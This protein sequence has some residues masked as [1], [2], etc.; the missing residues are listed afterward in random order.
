MSL[1]GKWYPLT[2]KLYFD[3]TNNMTEYEAC[4]MRVRM[5]YEMKIKRLRVL[6]DSLSIVHQLNG[7][8]ETRDAKLI[9]YNDYIRTLA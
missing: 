5:A 4:S 9:P 6:G 1:N 3:Y 8:R 7:E 2:T